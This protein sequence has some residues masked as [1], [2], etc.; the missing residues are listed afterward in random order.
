[1]SEIQNCK[2]CGEDAML[3][4]ISDGSFC[5]VRRMSYCKRYKP[6]G[7]DTCKTSLRATPEEAIREW[8]DQHSK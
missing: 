3:L 2:R 6:G 4:T 1:M 5:R 7:G 8:N